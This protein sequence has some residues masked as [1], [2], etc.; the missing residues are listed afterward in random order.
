MSQSVTS[1]R[2][3]AKRFIPFEIPNDPQL[4]K[5]GFT[6]GE[7]A[8]HVEY[9]EHCNVPTVIHINPRTHMLAVQTVEVNG[10]QEMQVTLVPMDGD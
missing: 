4:D 3:E 6:S 10:K 9:P 2:L 5:H 7:T 8:Q 1:M